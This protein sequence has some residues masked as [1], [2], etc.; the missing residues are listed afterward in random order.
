ML[1]AGKMKE[2]STTTSYH[3]NKSSAKLFRAKMAKYTV[4][5]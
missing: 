5:S 2:I 1:V 4:Q 3:E